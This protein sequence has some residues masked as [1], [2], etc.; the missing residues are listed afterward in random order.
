MV[1]FNPPAYYH[2]LDQF[3]GPDEIQE[4]VMVEGEEWKTKLG[5]DAVGTSANPFQHQTQALAARIREGAGRV[6]L[7]FPGA[8]K[9]NAQQA[10]PEAY[11]TREREDLREL[12]RVAGI[13]TST[14]ATFQRQGFAGLGERGF[15]DEQRF[16]NI[17]EVKKAIEFAAEGTTGGAIV[18]HTGEWQRPI[19]ETWGKGQDSVR[20]DAEFRAYEEESERATFY[21]VDERTGEFVSAIRKDKNLYRP[22][23]MTAK[24]FCPDKIGKHDDLKGTQH[25]YGQSLDLFPRSH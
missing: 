10:S 13:K 18:F 24:E 21:M 12:A 9:S 20:S 22:I 1:I 15:S 11:G 25:H 3:Q 2:S 7:N 23:Y 19:S 16:Q 8:G 5:P 17:K 6:E 14:H 4:P